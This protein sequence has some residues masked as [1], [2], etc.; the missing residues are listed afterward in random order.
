MPLQP[1]VQDQEGRPVG[2]V[3]ER[4]IGEERPLRTAQ[5]LRPR[6]AGLDQARVELLDQALGRAVADGPER[7]EGA[8]GARL[9]GDPGQS[10]GGPL[11]ALRG[12]ARREQQ[13]L[14]GRIAKAERADGFGQID[15]KLPKAEQ[16]E[17]LGELFG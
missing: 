3:P 17:P 12:L 14:E 6:H 15:L 11:V 7:G 4:G 5:R 2:R 10:Q 16:G 9:D 13:E 1:A 8:A